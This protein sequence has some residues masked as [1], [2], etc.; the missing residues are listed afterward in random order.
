L[1]EPVGVPA[2]FDATKDHFALVATRVG[3]PTFS[4]TVEDYNQAWEPVTHSIVN[5]ALRWQKQGA[6]PLLVAACN[7][8]APWQFD[9]HFSRNSVSPGDKR[10]ISVRQVPVKFDAA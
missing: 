1:V 5:G 4:P 8:S 7:Y 9:R 6:L 3:A 10:T 2:A